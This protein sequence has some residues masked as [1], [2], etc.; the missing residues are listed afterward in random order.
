LAAAGAPV[1]WR[2]AGNPW[3]IYP[4][5]YTDT[6]DA[7]LS[8]RWDYK[9]GRE[10]LEWAKKGVPIHDAVAVEARIKRPGLLELRKLIEGFVLDQVPGFA[11]PVV[12][13][14]LQKYLSQALGAIDVAADIAGAASLVVISHGPPPSP[15]AGGLPSSNTPPPSPVPF[16]ISCQLLSTGDVSGLLGGGPAQT[17]FPPMHSGD[18]NACEYRPTNVNWSTPWSLVGITVAPTHTIDATLTQ[19]T[20]PL[21]GVGDEAYIHDG[22]GDK[23]AR[24]VVRSGSTVLLVSVS[25]GQANAQQIVLSLTRTAIGHL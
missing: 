3:L 16:A 6:L 21:S 1:R 23:S 22:P 10:P 5:P 4:V 14:V 8:A 24:L 25:V 2:L 17:F 19:G 12:N 11:Q 15:P 18:G 9:T 20:T 7:N 13:A